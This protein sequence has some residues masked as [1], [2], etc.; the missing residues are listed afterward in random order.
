MLNAS[1]AKKMIALC[2]V[3]TSLIIQKVYNLNSLKHGFY[4]KKVKKRK[5]NL[6]I[7]TL[8]FK[9]SIEYKFELHQQ[10]NHSMTKTGVFYTFF[11]FKLYITFMHRRKY[12]GSYRGW[13]LDSARINSNIPLCVRE[14]VRCPPARPVR[15]PNFLFY[16]SP[17]VA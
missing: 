13:H 14:P 6:N 4:S 11:T 5:L 12:R 3:N 7:V 10:R 8:N 15:T 9:I 17:F 1:V 2:K 16:S